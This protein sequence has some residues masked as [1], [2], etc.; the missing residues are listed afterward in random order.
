[1][2]SSAVFSSAVFSSAVMLRIIASCLIVASTGF[3]SFRADLMSLIV[4]AVTRHRNVFIP[5]FRGFG[6]ARA[7][8]RVTIDEHPPFPT[9]VMVYS[10]VPWIGLRKG[11][12][13]EMGLQAGEPVE[14]RVELD[15]AP[16]EVDVPAELAAALQAD[17]A[18]AAAYEKLSFTH[19]KEYARWVSEAKREP[20]RQD[21]A[22]KT[23]ERLKGGIK[24]AF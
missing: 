15:G 16:R 17:P 11:Q 24:P 13:A 6:K 20:T 23:I 21:R 10:G 8:V 2:R 3:A 12:I 7:P 4:R 1:M 19:R 14:V 22:A 9:T 5:H 18:A